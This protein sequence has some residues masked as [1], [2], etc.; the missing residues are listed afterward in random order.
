MI[1]AIKETKDFKI[2]VNITIKQNGAIAII[3]IAKILQEMS[4]SMNEL[5][6]KF[7]RSH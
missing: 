5:V 2:E 6:N 3:E 4:D 1:V 7:E